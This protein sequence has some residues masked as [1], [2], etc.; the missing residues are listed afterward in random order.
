MR[1][2]PKAAIVGVTG[3]IGRGLPSLLAESGW[4]TT[5][6][7]R[8]G[9]G[10]VSGVTRWQ[11]LETMDFS[12]HQAVINLAG[13]PIDQ[14]WTRRA[15]RLFHESRI[16]TTRRVVDAIAKLP[17]GERPGVL[18]NGSAVGIYG[19][20]G[21]EILT[22]ASSPGSGYL[23]ELC[24]EWEEAAL[25]AESLGVRVVRLRTGVVLGREGKAFAK[26]KKVFR[27]GIGGRLGNG[28]QWMPWIH[29]EDLREG[30]IH[31]ILNEDLKGPINGTSPTPERNIDF[32]K[33][34]AA[35]VHRPAILPAGK[36]ALKLAFGE[37]G[38]TLLEGQRAL[39]AVLEASGF[40]FHFPTLE[41]ALADLL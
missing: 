12:D 39:P 16:G 8:A 18:I 10:S 5:G 4:G 31:A 24:S 38:G 41:S 11:S 33:K 2:K 28:Q 29:L 14:R 15:K 17:D 30:I 20:R 1:K 26:L 34:L 6:V 27:L 37:F 25:A 22:E 21:D 9:S 13:E 7:S 32:T 35:A 23:A 3:F 36:V 19:D 40:R